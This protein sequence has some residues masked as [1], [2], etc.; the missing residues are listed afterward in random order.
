MPNLNPLS[1][2]LDDNKL[3]GQNF[4]DWKRNLL[5]VLTA[6]KIAYVL[7]KDEP[8]LALSDATEEE[9]VSYD[10][11]HE[12]D[13]LAK[14]YILASMTNMLQKQCENLVNAKDMITSLQEMF[15]EHSKS[16]RQQIMKLLMTTKLVEGASVRDYVPNMM[17][18]IYELESLGAGMDDKTK[19][20]VILAS[21]PESFNQF[22]LN[23]NMNKMDVTLPELL[24]MLQSAEELIKN[25]KGFPMML[26]REKSSLMV[27]DKSTCSELKPKGKK[28]KKNKGSQSSRDDI[29]G[30]E[31][32]DKGNCFH[33]GK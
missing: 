4:I 3:N 23:Y 7:T 5:I 11:W 18:Y 12:D 9:N 2:I 20:G 19:V 32:K 27:M 16:A 26:D 28:F 10:K 13:E 14:C 1:R 33:C 22:V 6:E 8:K 30:K 21:L 29:S 25:E 24:N 15:G 31:K 17:S